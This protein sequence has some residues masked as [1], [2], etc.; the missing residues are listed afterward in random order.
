[1][2]RR[3]RC[4]CQCELLVKL[5]AAAPQL[6]DHGTG[7]RTATHVAQGRI[8]DHV[9]GVAGAQEI[10]KVQSALAG[11]R[12]E[13]GEAVVANLR[14]EAIL[15]GVARAGIVHRDP[16]RRLQPGP[17]HVAVFGKKPVLTI[18]QQTH[19]LALRDADPDGAQ[20]RDQPLHRHLALV[21]LQQYEAAQL[22]TPMTLT[23]RRP[24]RHR[25]PAAG[26]T[27][28]SRR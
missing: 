24:R 1:M 16:S 12:G 7:K 14:A 23:P 28:R 22:R 19:H 25:H 8:I 17:Q 3:S 13:P 11:P 15:S 21:V 27:Q 18:N 2:P 20:L 26:V 9:I 5:S 10:E 6:A 4:A